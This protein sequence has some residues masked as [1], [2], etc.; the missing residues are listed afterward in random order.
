MAKKPTKTPSGKNTSGRGQRDLKVKV[1]TAR[2]R[3]LSSTLW[4]QRQLNDPY[5]KRAK[6]EGYRG[7]AAFKIL[8]TDDKYRFLVPGA[9][10]VDLGCAPG[11]WCQVA[12][13]RVNALGEKQGKAKGFV[14]GIDLQ[15]VDQIPGAELHVLDF[16]ADGADDKVKAW[17]G[18]KADVVMSDM[19]AA[20]SGHKQTD[21]LRIIA[22]CE[23]AAYLAF[24]VL[25]EGGTF[26]AK[27]LQGGA[28]GTLQA[29]LKRRFEKVSNFKPGASRA[30]S[31]EK[32][33]V[34]TG[35]RG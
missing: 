33:V 35:F 26:V 5:V 8:E 9:R 19:A 10:V 27:V 29:E 31:S 24:D 25:E 30:D 32:F 11:G 28:E 15:V 13:P 23:A 16:M 2:G 18:G 3:K 20:S 7:R 17:L 22:L 14:L 4:L 21:H 34:A 6:E 12:V 1:K